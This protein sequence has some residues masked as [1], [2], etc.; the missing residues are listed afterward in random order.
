MENTPSTPVVRPAVGIKAMNWAM[1]PA[2]IINPAAAP[3]DLF[4]WVVAEVESLHTWLDILA[5][6]SCAFEIEPPELAALVNE[7][8]APV[9]QGLRAALESGRG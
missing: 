3:R 7:R 5:C 1:H 6:S 4:S 9:M 8:L 2:L